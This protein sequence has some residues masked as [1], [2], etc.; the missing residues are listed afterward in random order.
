MPTTKKQ[1]NIY[2][3]IPASV[4]EASKAQLCLILTNVNI[5]NKNIVEFVVNE[6][7]S[8]YFKKIDG[9]TKLQSTG[10]NI[11]KQEDAIKIFASYMQKSNEA[12]KLL[13]Q[14]KSYAKG[15]EIPFFP[16]SYLKPIS[17]EKKPLQ[18]GSN[19]PPYYWSCN[20]RLEVTAYQDM[21]T[22]ELIKCNIANASLQ[23]DLSVRGYIIGMQYNLIPFKPKGKVPL[24]PILTKEGEEPQV[25]YLVN[26]KLGYIT[27]FYLSLNG[28]VAACKESVLPASEKIIEKNEMYFIDEGTGKYLG[29]F[30]SEKNTSFSICSINRADFNDL[31]KNNFNTVDISSDIKISVEDNSKKLNI[32]I[33]KI[34]RDILTISEKK[35]ITTIEGKEAIEQA[36]FFVF[37]NK[38][39][40]ITSVLLPT[41][42]NRHNIAYHLGLQGTTLKGGENNT[43][44]YLDKQHIIIAEMHSHP[45]SPLKAGQ[46]SGTSFIFA[47]SPNSEKIPVEGMSEGDK[48]FAFETNIPVYALVTFSDSKVFN[49]VYYTTREGKEEF[50]NKEIASN[51]NN[52]KLNPLK[53]LQHVVKKNY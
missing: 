26:N 7:G 27:P 8:F 17:C 48:I 37:D 11:E 14:A 44:Y 1:I 20:Y 24:Y 50:T 53:F 19:N 52:I 33:E 22:S 28:F 38:K 39:N 25:N 13:A 4:I 35:I 36:M 46:P 51:L 16:T 21:D 23:I 15:L 3:T 43:P 31:N 40:T 12:I 29:S 2:S 18:T 34:V 32:E 5:A 6:N 41:D 10:V 30:T 42:N 47:D 45:D 9:Y 49:N